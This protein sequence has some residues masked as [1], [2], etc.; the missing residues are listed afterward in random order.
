MLGVGRHDEAI[1]EYERVLEQKPDESG[2]LNNLS[3]VLATSTVD[4]LRD[5]QRSL[6][7]A[8][9]AC[10][11]TEYKLPHVISTLAA[12]HAEL[13]NFEQAIEWSTKAVELEDPD[14]QEQLERELESYRN[15]KPWRERTVHEE[16]ADSEQPSD[17]D[18]DLN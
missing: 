4:E 8:Q 6:E 1:K 3:W 2:A 5:G 16:K 18:L 13:G 12:A 7:L 10:E 14:R 15:D 11:V 9:K 17:D